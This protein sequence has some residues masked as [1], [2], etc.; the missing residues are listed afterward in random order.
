MSSILQYWRV[1]S[2]SGMSRNVEIL[3]PDQNTAGRSSGPSKAS[4]KNLE[5]LLAGYTDPRICW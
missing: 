3:L 4:R 2:A 5:R 1:L